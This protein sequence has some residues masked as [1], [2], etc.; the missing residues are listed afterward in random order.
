MVTAVAVTFD[1]PMDP[2]TLLTLDPEVK[3]ERQ[4]LGPWTVIFVP[5]EPL[6][7]ASHFVVWVPEG[8]KALDG[9]SLAADFLWTF[10]TQRPALEEVTPPNDGLLVDPRGAL[11]L[12]FN[13]PIDL[14]SLQERA[15]LSWEDDE[16]YKAERFTLEPHADAQGRQDLTRVAL[17]PARPI[18]PGAKVELT[19]QAGLQGAQGKL[20]CRRP[21]RHTVWTP[22]VF[23]ALRAT[24]AEGD[25]DKRLCDPDAGFVIPLS[26]KPAQGAA[27]ALVSKPPIPPEQV[28]LEDGAIRVL[29]PL[30]PSTRYKLSLST[31]ARDEAGRALAK[32]FG[33][34]LSTHKRLAPLAPVAAPEPPADAPLPAP[35]LRGVVL[36]PQ[37]ELVPDAPLYARAWLAPPEGEPRSLAGASALV[38]V[39][40]PTGQEVFAKRAALD[41]VGGLSLAWRVPRG[42][43]AGLWS[44]SVQGPQAGASARFRVGGATPPTISAQATPARVLG[45]EPLHLAVLAPNRARQRLPW[46]LTLAPSR[47]EAEG[48]PGYTFGERELDPSPIY[49]VGSAALDERGQGALALPS[50][51]SGAWRWS[52][53]STLEGDE[54]PLAQGE[55]IPAPLSLGV[56]AK[57]GLIRLGERVVVRVAAANADGQAVSRA[58]LRATLERQE[59]LPDGASAWREVSVCR[60]ETGAA[61]V[62]CGFTPSEPGRWR[63]RVTGQAGGVQGAPCVWSLWV[64]GPDARG[65]AWTPDSPPLVLDRE[66]AQL[67][68]KLLA[69]VRAPAGG[70]RGALTL[71]GAQGV[72]SV[73]LAPWEGWRLL[74]LPLGLAQ[75]P[76]V[77][78]SLRWR[79]AGG[80]PLPPADRRVRV[81]PQ[82]RALEVRV[83]APSGAPGEPIEATVEVSR[84]GVPVEAS[85]TLALVDEVGSAQLPRVEPLVERLWG[86]LAEP[87][88]REAAPRLHGWRAEVRTDAQGRARLGWVLPSEPGALR[89]VAWANDGRG[90]V[91]VSEARLESV[92]A[93]D[94]RAFSPARGSAGDEALVEVWLTNRADRPAEV[95]WSLRAEGVAALVGGEPQGRV[96][97]AAKERRVLWAR[98]GL[99]AQGVGRLVVLAQAEEGEAQAREVVSWEVAARPQTA[100]GGRGEVWGGLAK[101]PTQAPPEAQGGTVKLWLDAAPWVRARPLWERLGREAERGDADE[102]S[103]RL[104]AAAVLL[105]PGARARLGADERLALER[106]VE[107]CFEGLRGLQLPEGGFAPWPQR[108]DLDVPK[109]LRAATALEVAQ[110]AGLPVPE[111]LRRQTRAWLALL[112]ARR[113][114]PLSLRPLS[115]DELAWAAG[116]LSGVDPGRVSVLSD[117]D[118]LQARADELG[119]GGLGWLALA[120][121]RRTRAQPARESLR[122][123][124]ERL[125][126]RADVEQGRARVPRPGGLDSSEGAGAVWVWALSELAPDHPMARWLALDLLSAQPATL[127][128]EALSLWALSRLHAERP[129]AAPTGPM[130]AWWGEEVALE[131][132]PGGLGG[133][134]ERPWGA[135][136]AWTLEAEEGSQGAFWAEGA[137][138]VKP[139]P[140]VSQ[141]LAVLRSWETAQGQPLE[142]VAALGEEVVV[143]LTLVLP[144]ALERAVLEDAGGPC[145]EPTQVL[146][147]APLA[148][149]RAFP[150]ATFQ[151]AQATASGGV[152]FWADTLGPGIVEHTWRARVVCRGSFLVPPARLGPT[153]GHPQA[154][155]A[156]SPLEVE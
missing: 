137:W 124:V 55:I 111:D 130:R 80:E 148:E 75:S 110:A 19:I 11:W 100:R 66:E 69:L 134:V 108:L 91:G 15:G 12:R 23:R 122:A 155:S 146:T 14:R 5:D 112:L 150:R 81:S 67:G 82:A 20:P 128:D 119:A 24:C 144:S 43:H 126:R 26:A 152:L 78:V 138:E 17:V 18:P 70:A 32:P 145:L 121:H 53:A 56:Q 63:V 142:G 153:L 46:R 149:V 13:Q 47:W 22:D 88:P 151:R 3:G 16:Q 50:P 125:E 104:L 38:R 109:S 120:W 10:T 27:L 64:V 90:R 94:L 115:G 83:E 133:W 114:A 102:L 74:E 34:T 89:L 35:P 107:R 57:R 48:L 21:W 84:E 147:R 62:V 131:V 154:Q 31:S 79:G 92:A 96:T 1:R 4:W 40:D 52:L 129:W 28:K 9:T 118:P 93:L 117:L 6:P 37:A 127:Y 101:L 54:L 60:G 8:A 7:P 72:Q 156:A 29:G 59:L 87:L 61:P 44:L 30:L 41:E 85:L 68:E 139:E 141:G 99:R 135:G 25:P 42:A 95:S 76:W 58:Q 98:V 113:Q 136:K 36:M 132:P 2:S 49:N 65:P 77:D 97:L 45:G 71:A 103:A 116:L 39:T 123:L 33:A 73:E 143:R 140:R 106:S 86:G 105:G 51:A